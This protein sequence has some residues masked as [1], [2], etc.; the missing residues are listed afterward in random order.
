MFDGQWTQTTTILSNSLRCASE[1]DALNTPADSSDPVNGGC[2]ASWSAWIL[3]T[4]DIVEM[5]DDGFGGTYDISSESIK[6]GILYTISQ[7]IM[8]ICTSLLK[9]MPT[10]V[11]ILPCGAMD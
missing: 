8:L 5:W 11:T 2:E 3:E 1:E 6:L 10:T 9:M 4:L 7:Y